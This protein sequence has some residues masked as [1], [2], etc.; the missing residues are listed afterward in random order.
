MQVYSCGKKH[1]DR[2]W[3]KEEK[4]LR[5]YYL[6]LKVTGKYNKLKKE[7]YKLFLFYEKVFK[8]SKKK[9]LLLSLRKV[10]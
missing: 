9:V 2:N 4:L 3:I 1:K 8:R 7:N 5:T 6:F 10:L